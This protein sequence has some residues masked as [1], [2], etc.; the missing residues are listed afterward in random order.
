MRWLRKNPS[1]RRS[2]RFSWKRRTAASPNWA[3]CC[4]GWETASGDGQ[5]ASH[6]GLILRALHTLKGSAR[7]AGA[8]ALGQAAHEMETLL[9]AAVRADRVGPVLFVRLY[10]WYDR[11]LAHSEALQAGRLLPVDDADLINA[12]TGLN[13]APADMA[14]TPV[15]AQDAPQDAPQGGGE[16]SPAPLARS[17]V[18]PWLQAGPVRPVA[19]APGD[20]L[21]PAADAG[22]RQRALVRVQ[23][24]TLDTLITD[25]GEVGATRARL[26][27]ELDAM[28][29]YL[30]E[31]NDNVARLR[32]QLQRDRDPGGVADGLAH[33]RRPAQAGI[34]SARVRPLHA[35]PGTDADDG[36]VG[37]R[38]GHRRAEPAAGL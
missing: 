34:R 15:P 23:A 3:S 13:G 27:S 38:R 26:E 2:S 21:A 6:A 5:H 19:P 24:R 36:R 32:G 29:S 37:Q 33:R 17:A 11:I 9:D 30:G 31:L 4:A 7:M 16:R 22:E 35:L 20:A 12:M 8:M 25:A 28:R 14:G 10:A 1:I 18:Q